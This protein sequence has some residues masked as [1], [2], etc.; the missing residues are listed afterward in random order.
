MSVTLRAWFELEQKLTS[1]FVD[2]SCAVVITTTPW[3]LK[4]LI[5]I[6]IWWK[7]M[8]WNNFWIYQQIFIGLLSVWTIGSFS[9]SLAFNSKGL[10]KC[11][12]LNN[13]PCQARA[14][15]VNINCNETP[16]YPFTVSVNKYGEICNTI[17]CITCNYPYAHVCV[18]NR[19]KNMNVKVFNLISWVNKARYIVEHESCK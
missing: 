17:I 9:A 4:L 16:F 2:W 18:Q 14:P 6:N 5:F 11:A 19:V 1:S 12:P 8:I 13:Q 3:V 10:I 15:V 7:N